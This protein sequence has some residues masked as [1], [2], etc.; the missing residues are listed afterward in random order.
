MDS[1]ALDTEA[2]DVTDSTRV[3]VAVA[4]DEVKRAVTRVAWSGG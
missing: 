3:V 4:V 2:V 1:A